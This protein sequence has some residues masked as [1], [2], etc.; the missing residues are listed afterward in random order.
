MPSRHYLPRSDAFL[1]KN[2]FLCRQWIGVT[3]K[4]KKFG[5]NIERN[6]NYMSMYVHIHIYFLFLPST[7][8]LKMQRQASALE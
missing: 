8:Q 7:P 1:R 6:I 4:R 5:C 2:C 3:R